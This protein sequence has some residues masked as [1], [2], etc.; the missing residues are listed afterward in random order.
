MS[1]STKL[2]QRGVFMKSNIYSNTFEFNKDYQLYF[3]EIFLY[4]IGLILIISSSYIS[5]R[6]PISLVP[7]TAQTLIVLTLGATYGWKRA[8]FVLTSYLTLGL[9]GFEVFAGSASGV[10][11][12]VGPTGGYL[13][14]FLISSAIMGLISEYFEFDKKLAS[15]FILFMVG[16]TIIF[17]FGI[18][19]L[20]NFTGIEQAILTGFLPFIPGEFIKSIM[21][22][23]ITRTLWKTKI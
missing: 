12:L 6:I 17:A 9:I 22:A 2:L 8:T 23:M 18:L 4:I 20:S 1:T 21:A 11:S 14:G 5:I 16:H 3:Y 7:I 10:T 19:W 15:A 13:I